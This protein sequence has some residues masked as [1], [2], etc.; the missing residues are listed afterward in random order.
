MKLSEL[1]PGYAVSVVPG[2]LRVSVVVVVDVETCTLMPAAMYVVLNVVVD[3]AG[4]GL[5]WTRTVRVPVV[6]AVVVRA[7]MV[8]VDVLR[9]VEVEEMVV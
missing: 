2:T 4:R 3:F 8:L 1:Q 6:V 7:G 9:P 5:R